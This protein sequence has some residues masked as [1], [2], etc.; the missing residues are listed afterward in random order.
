M[1]DDGFSLA[2]THA[3]VTG[4]GSGIGRAIAISLDA[5]GANVSILGRTEGTLRETVAMFTGDGGYAVA[6]VTDADAV[7]LAVAKRIDAAGPIAIL[8]NNAGAAESAPMHKTSRALWDKMLAINLSSVF[9]VTQSVLKSMRGLEKGRII[10][11]SSTAGLKGYSYVSAYCAAKHGLIGFTRSVALEL[12]KTP[13][14][15]NAVCPGFTDTPILERSLDNI[16]Q[17]T[18]LDRSGA[19]ETLASVNPQ[20]R[21]ITPDEVANTVLWLCQDSSYGIT[22]QSIVIAGGEI[23]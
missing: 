14:T 18:G 5:A 12:A 19:R 22:G 3:L 7:E 10:N 23:M 16:S 9:I 13:I 1:A 17:T 11:V 6:D 4:G 21:I 8:V 2:G 15:V 20:E